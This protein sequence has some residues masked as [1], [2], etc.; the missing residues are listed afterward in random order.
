[1]HAVLGTFQMD[2]SKAAAQQRELEERIVPMVRHQPG[3]VA[4]YWSVEPSGRSHSYIVW[5]T[6]AQARALVEMVEGNVARQTDH[7]VAL[8]SLSVFEVIASAQA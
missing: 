6:E 5:E 8:Q 4:G 3:F 7:G 1:M 2:M